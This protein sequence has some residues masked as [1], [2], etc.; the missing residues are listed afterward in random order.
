[1]TES[2][3][4]RPRIVAKFIDDVPRTLTQWAAHFGINNQTLR[5]RQHKHGGVLLKA[6]YAIHD[7]AEPVF[8]KGKGVC[9]AGH[10]IEGDNVLIR[11]EKGEPH[12]RCRKCYTNEGAFQRGKGLCKK[13]HRVEGDN[14]IMRRESGILQPRCKLCYAKPKKPPSWKTFTIESIDSVPRSVNQWARWAGVDDII[15]RKHLQRGRP[16]EEAVR[17]L[18]DGSLRRR[19]KKNPNGRVT[20]WVSRPKHSCV[21]PS[22]DDVERG[23]VEWAAYLGINRLTLEKR[24]HPQGKGKRRRTRTLEQAVLFTLN[25]E[26]HSRNTGGKCK[27]GH[28]VT[29]GNSCRECAKEADKKRRAE[30]RRKREAEKKQKKMRLMCKKGA[31]KMTGRNVM[32][33]NQGNGVISEQ[34]RACRYQ[35]QNQRN[36][37]LRAGEW[38]ARADYGK[39]LEDKI[40][41]NSVPG[42]GGCVI[43]CGKLDGQGYP[44]VNYTQS[45]KLRCVALV[46]PLVWNRAHPNDRTGPG[47]MLKATCDNKLCIAVGHLRKMHTAE[48]MHSPEVIEKSRRTRARKFSAGANAIAGRAMEYT[49]DIRTTLKKS[50]R[51]LHTEIDDIA[52][53][54]VLRICHKWRKNQPIKTLK[55]LLLA[56]TRNIAQDRLRYYKVRQVHRTSSIFEDAIAAEI[57][58]RNGSRGEPSLLLG[59]PAELLDQI[60]QYETEERRYRWRLNRLPPKMR[61]IFDMRLRGL[62]QEEIAKKTGRSMNTVE[63]H[64]AKAYKIMRGRYNS[65]G[66]EL[67]LNPASLP[68]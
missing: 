54:A 7:G 32:R 65:K 40:A 17:G 11:I 47:F 46:R 53:E 33:V 44:K 60:E 64:L 50:F 10:K 30:R 35:Y 14:I 16:L 8:K 22:V 31:H 59:D 29:P 2:S 28:R 25:N 24:L 66:F 26:W 36:A 20:R 51:V 5:A 1:M 37:R 41:I 19:T 56:T 61:A 21:I 15:L 57:D 58:T 12:E 9:R 67:L 27:R 68:V 23:V 39:S 55:G 38:R 3:G 62:S 43:W 4:L 63:Q 49:N 48:L 52:Q 18:K 34:C 45:P 6:I 42:D 13:G